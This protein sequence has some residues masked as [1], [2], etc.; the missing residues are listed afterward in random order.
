MGFTSCSKDEDEV[1][2]GI[3]GLVTD[4]YNSGVQGVS[5]TLNPSGKKA[6][7]GSDGR[8]E[9]LDLEPR[10]YTVQFSKSGY[11]SNVLSATV[12]PGDKTTADIVLSEGVNYLKLS[13]TQLNFTGATNAMSFEVENTGPSNLSWEI[14]LNCPWIKSVRPATGDLASGRASSIS[15]VID[16]TM[17]NKGINEYAL[18]INSDYGN[19]VVLVRAN[20]E[21]K[22]PGDGDINIREGLVVYYQFDNENGD[23]SSLNEFRGSFPLGVTFTDD[24]PSGEG[25]SIILSGLRNQFFRIPRDLIVSKNSFSIS[26]W[27]KNLGNGIIFTTKTSGNSTREQYPR[28][29]CSD[30]GLLL[31]LNVGHEEAGEKLGVYAN[32]LNEDWHLLTLAVR[33]IDG[34][35]NESKLYID[36]ELE[37]TV[38]SG[39][40]VNVI[41]SEVHI[42][43][44]LNGMWKGPQSTMMFDNVRIYNKVLNDKEV[45]AIYNDER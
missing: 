25:K 9:F 36:G 38:N 30:E 45:K 22:D 14:P 27:V 11:Q 10:Q 21:D 16:R 37:T 44:N 41:A 20:S 7:T 6:T 35:Q 43:G 39:T 23:D 26:L 40:V 4:A 5:V 19:G 17:L 42:G 32:T 1:F 28:L 33:K 8:Y 29:V 3:Y 2:G 24:T 31:S 15:V 34:Y 13:K 18:I 12:Y